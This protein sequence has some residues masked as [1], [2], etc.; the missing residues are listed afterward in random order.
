MFYI[1]DPTICVRKFLHMKKLHTRN[2]IKSYIMLK[3]QNRTD[4]VIILLSPGY[5]GLDFDQG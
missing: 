4:N 5:R 1:R 2:M 3:C